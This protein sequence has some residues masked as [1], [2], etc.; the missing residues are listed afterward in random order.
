VEPVAMDPGAAKE[1]EVVAVVLL[2]ELSVSAL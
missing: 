2:G 1:V